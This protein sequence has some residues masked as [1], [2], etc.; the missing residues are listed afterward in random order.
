METQTE[1][2]I[3]E[4]RQGLLQLEKFWILQDGLLLQLSALVTN[5]FIFYGSNFAH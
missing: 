4:Q 3:S 5:S 1:G 2:L